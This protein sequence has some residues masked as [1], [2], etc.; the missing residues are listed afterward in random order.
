M[1]TVSVLCNWSNDAQCVLLCRDPKN[2]RDVVVKKFKA[3]KDAGKILRE[4][5]YNKQACK[6]GFAPKVYGYDCEKKIIIME[7]LDENLKD[8]LRRV[9]RISRT[10]DRAITNLIYRVCSSKI[11]NGSLKCVNIMRKGSEWYLIDYGRAG[12]SKTADKYKDIYVSM[13]KK[14]MLSIAT[15]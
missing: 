14:E 12:P 4:V 6:L 13:I 7:K 11:M 15:H 5:H 10:T 3:E 8:Y 9:K 1:K 2:K